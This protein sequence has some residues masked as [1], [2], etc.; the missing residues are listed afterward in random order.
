MIPPPLATVSASRVPSA[1]SRHASLG[2]IGPQPTAQPMSC[3][4]ITYDAASADDPS[5]IGS[6][7]NGL[8]SAIAVTHAPFTGGQVSPT[9]SMRPSDRN[10]SGRAKVKLPRAY[11]ATVPSGKVTNGFEPPTVDPQSATAAT[12]PSPASAVARTDAKE[13]GTCGLHTYDSVGTGR[14]R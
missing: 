11:S 7:A 2:T 12:R 4:S 9:S 3:A 13:P 10:A 1:R 14:A 8:P 5:T 6:A